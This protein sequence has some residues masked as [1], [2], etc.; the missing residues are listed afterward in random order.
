MIFNQG[1]GLETVWQ[2][3]LDASITQIPAGVHRH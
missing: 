2:G 3:L 1:L